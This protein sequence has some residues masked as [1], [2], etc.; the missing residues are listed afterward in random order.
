MGKTTSNVMGRV[1]RPSDAAP[2][3]WPWAK[4]YLC[5]SIPEAKALGVDDR[6]LGA[7]QGI[8]PA[9][10]EQRATVVGVDDGGREHGL[11]VTIEN[12][13]GEVKRLP[14]TAVALVP[15][16]VEPARSPDP[17]VEVDRHIV[18]S[19]KEDAARL[20]IHYFGQAVEL[21]GDGCAEVRSIVD[22]IV[23][24]AVAATHV[25]IERRWSEI[26]RK[27]SPSKGSDD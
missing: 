4:G 8:N 16:K 20:L 5:S 11:M 1:V 10:R 9:L 3:S 21:S 18:E 23:D 6:A 2:L 25:D 7:W 13:A 27:T 24:A 14:L 22:L 17:R 15:A 26:E 12:A 19:R